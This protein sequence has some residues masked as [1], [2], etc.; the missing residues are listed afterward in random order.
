MTDDGRGGGYRITV[1]CR[2]LATRNEVASEFSL[3][4]TVVSSGG[5]TGLRAA[6]R[7]CG[8]DTTHQAKA[9]W[10]IASVKNPG[11]YVLFPHQS[12]SPTRAQAR[13][14]THSPAQMS[15]AGPSRRGET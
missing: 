1:T 11:S 14:G 5:E 6:G 9:G 12:F 15:T 10:M 3:E 2:K 4:V 13:A 7:V 8:G